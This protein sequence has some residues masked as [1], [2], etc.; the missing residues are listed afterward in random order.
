M[1]A[2]EFGFLP[3]HRIKKSIARSW[4][5]PVWQRYGIY[6][7]GRRYGPSITFKITPAGSLSASQPGRPPCWTSTLAL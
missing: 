1:I 3:L 7:T 4:A 6:G 2:L 5:A